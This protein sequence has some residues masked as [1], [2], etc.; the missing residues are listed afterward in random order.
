MIVFKFYVGSILRDGIKFV[1][2]YGPDVSDVKFDISCKPLEIQSRDVAELLAYKLRAKGHDSIV[3]S[4][5]YSIND[6]IVPRS[7]DVGAL[8]F[9]NDLY[10]TDIA[11][12]FY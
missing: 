4:R 10:Y 11:N 1:T 9:F 7:D 12:N 3:V 6:H 2:S 5:S 8:T